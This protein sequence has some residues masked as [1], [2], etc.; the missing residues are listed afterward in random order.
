MSGSYGA[1]GARGLDEFSRCRAAGRVLH[2]KRCGRRSS[3]PAARLAPFVRQF[4]FVEADEQATRVLVP[5]GTAIARLPVRR[6][7]LRRGRAASS[8]ACRTRRSPG[9]ATPRG[10]CARRPA[11]EWCWRRSTPARRPRI[12]PRA[13]ARALRRDGPARRRSL[14]RAAVG[15]R[16]ARARG[17]GP[18]VARRRVRGTSCSRA[19]DARGSIP[20]SP[21][22]P[23]GSRPTP[24][25]CASRRSR[26]R[27]V[28]AR[29]GSRS[30][31]AARSGRRPSS[32]RRSCACAAR[33]T[34]TARAR[35]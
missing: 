16:R 22:R 26:A 23:A 19:C 21:R 29:T 3:H 6:P 28:S 20:W 35:R 33:S 15:D 13:A 7:R 12:L 5:D 4:T 18:R 32:S 30:A 34:R 24:P 31:S 2:W 1:A 25:A 17:E 9:C 14:R 8:C 10:G 27:S 11:A